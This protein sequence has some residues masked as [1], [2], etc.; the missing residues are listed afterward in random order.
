MN[1]VQLF[2][3]LAPARQK[4]L[5]AALAL[6]LA[7]RASLAVTSFRRTVDGFGHVPDS[8]GRDV[9][10]SEIRWAVTTAGNQ[11]PGT[12]C[13]PR[14]LVAHALCRRYGHPSHLYVGVDRESDEFAAHSWV[15]SRED[16]VVGDEVDLDRYE[17]LG[18]IAS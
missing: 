11:I 14:A 13:L 2:R 3:A 12:T 10:R 4:L 8:R 6:T 5:L 16:V 18:V 7:A 9:S 15:E 17:M 1:R